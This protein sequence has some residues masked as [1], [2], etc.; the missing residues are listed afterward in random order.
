MR[1]KAQLLRESQQVGED[2]GTVGINGMVR[3]GIGSVTPSVPPA[4]TAYKSPTAEIQ[5][6]QSET[7]FAKSIK[8][9]SDLDDKY[10]G[11]NFVLA[12]API[13]GMAELKGLIGAPDNWSK[14][15][16]APEPD[17]RTQAQKVFNSAGK[18]DTGLGVR[19]DNS[20][21]RNPSGTS[22]LGVGTFESDFTA[23][24][25]GQNAK[26]LGIVADG[27]TTGDGQATMGGAGAAQ[28]EE[29]RTEDK[30]ILGAVQKGI[31]D[32]LSAN[33]NLK[34]DEFEKDLE[35]WKSQGKWWFDKNA[36]YAPTFEEF[37]GEIP[38]ATDSLKDSMLIKADGSAGSNIGGAFMN[39]MAIEG[40]GSTA[41]KILGKS[42]G[43]SAYVGDSAMQGAMSSGFLGGIV[44]AIEG[45]MSWDSAQAADAKE[46]KRAYEEYK[47]QLKEWTIQKNKV[48]D[49]MKASATEDRL[50]DIRKTAEIGYQR[51]EKEKEQKKQSAAESRQAMID[52]LSSAGSFKASKRNER[53]NRWK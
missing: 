20:G 19:A 48:N 5:K 27:L 43:F 30:A 41:D 12:N 9:A 47:K 50:A 35:Y 17:F 6:R 8:S 15:L 53:M 33:K 18:E 7:D 44:G 21:I 29:P 40:V 4:A 46:K 11:T 22:K 31:G 3:G 1:D 38:S 28:A 10:T 14:Y 25:L 24:K 39:P 2:M 52:A 13:P 36:D 51:K 32:V 45:V 26:G 37:T 16:D 23:Q 49:Q 42:E 34:Q